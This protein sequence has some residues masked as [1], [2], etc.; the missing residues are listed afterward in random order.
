M[1]D[2]V[3]GRWLVCGGVRETFNRTAPM[4]AVGVDFEALPNGGS[5]KMYYLIAG[6]MGYV[7]G[8]GFAYELTYDISP[9]GK[10][11]QLNIHPAPNSGFGGS[12]RYSA[13]PR[14]LSMF[15]TQGTE[16]LLSAI[17]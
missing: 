7:R 9:L 15:V 1:Y 10:A 14:Q 3:A 6:P 17:P 16:A 13:C 11:F 12:P 8:A 4:D 2:A 5:G